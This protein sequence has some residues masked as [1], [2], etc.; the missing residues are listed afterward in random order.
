[1][2]H[3]KNRIIVLSAFSLFLLFCVTIFFLVLSPQASEI[4]ACSI[5]KQR[6]ETTQL[7]LS[8]AENR[9]KNWEAALQNTSN[10]PDLD[11]RKSLENLINDYKNRDVLDRKNA[12]ETAQHTYTA[13]TNP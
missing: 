5:E 10:T 1:M 13:C 7:E 12:V 2:R 8:V 6:L 4:A 3:A 11:Y 9:L